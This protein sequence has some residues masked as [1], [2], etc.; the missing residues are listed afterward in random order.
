[1][2]KRSLTAIA[3]VVASLV[4]AQAAFASLKSPTRAGLSTASRSIHGHCQMTPASRGS[5]RL[6]AQCLRSSRADLRYVFTVP[7][8]AHGI[9]GRVTYAWHTG[10]IAKRVT[11]SGRRVTL[12]VHVPANARAE[13]V[14]ASIQYYG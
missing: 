9:V 13:I 4:I 10:G 1:M 11:R 12:T 2:I 8:S 7:R 5:K 14:S 3:I 6:H